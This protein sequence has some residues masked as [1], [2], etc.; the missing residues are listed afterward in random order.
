MIY[1]L[2]AD[3]GSTKTDWAL[4]KDDERVQR[5]ATQGINP[6]MLEKSEIVNILNA[7]LLPQLGDIPVAVIEFYG[8]GC[9]GDQ[10]GL[11]Q[12]ALSEVFSA[13]NIS[14][15]SDMLGAARLLCHTD[16]G[17]VCIL[18]TGS[19]SCLYDGYQIVQNVSPL[20]FILG[21]EGSGAV[22]GKR[23]LGDI[24][25]QQLPPSVVEAFFAEYSLT[26]DEIIRK[27]YKESFPNRFL[28]SFCPFL[29]RHLSE[30]TVHDLLVDEFK[31]FFSR[32]VA[33][34]SRQDLPVHFVGSVAFHFHELLKEAAAATG[35][36]VGKIKKVPLD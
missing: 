15:D 21:D 3:S 34:Y 36:V 2:L 9:R 31:R 8:A 29:S 35:F 23:L 19:N 14:V 32:N 22:L 1:K 20:G 6:F 33:N 25:K 13:E 4:L 16:E 27:V 5:F 28:A 7:E 24:L 10:C 30:P 17:I 26:S 18:G 12:S 11:V